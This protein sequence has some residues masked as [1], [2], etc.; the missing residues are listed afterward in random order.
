[1]KRRGPLGLATFLTLLALPLSTGGAGGAVLQDRQTSRSFDVKSGDVEVT[2]QSGDIRVSSWSRS[3]VLVQAI[4]MGRRLRIDESAGVVR[5]RGSRGSRGGRIEISVPVRSELSLRTQ[6]G[7]IRIR[8]RIAGRVRALTSSGDVRVDEIDGEFVADT[9][10]GDID[11][12]R[13]SGRVDLRTSGG[14]LTVRDV[15]GDLRA[16]TSGGHIEAGDVKGNL[17]ARTSGGDIRAGMVAKNAD[18]NTSGGDVVLG[19]AGGQ[20]TLRTSGGDVEL[21][22][23]AAAAF[24]RTAGGDIVLAMVRDAL[25]ART[26]GGDIRAEIAS[27]L[28]Q[29]SFLIT[30]GGQIDLTVAPD[31]KATIEAVIRLQGSRWRNRDSD[32]EIRSEFERSDYRRSDRIIQ[33]TYRLNGGG[34][35]IL[36]ESVNGDIRILRSR[37]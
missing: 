25:E 13:L 10:G 33:A 5:V 22:G 35:R 12:G 27:S 6:G 3:Q 17:D 26:A 20:A 36:L 14:D 31:L 15:D 34:P 24:A 7:D 11:G 19:G 28:K 9:S 2:I 16:V 8:G 1:M 23:S 21:R 4:G 30:K 18:L 29:E 32:Y 37:R